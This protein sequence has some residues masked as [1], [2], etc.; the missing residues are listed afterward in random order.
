MLAVIVMTFCLPAAPASDVWTPPPAWLDRTMQLESS[1]N[2]WAV[3]DGGR[4]R[5]PYQIQ[6]RIWQ[7]YG[8]RKP[9]S[10]WAHNPGESRRVARIILDQCASACKRVG[11][12]VTF[13]NV[14]WFY[15]HGGF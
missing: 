13:T 6:R 1:G 3:G 4:S 5:G 7:H 8:G 10:T 14:R 11:K 12:P 2:R 9:W 15:R